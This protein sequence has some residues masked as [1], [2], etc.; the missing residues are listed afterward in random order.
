MCKIAN[1]VQ[2][3]IYI[4]QSFNGLLFYINEKKGGHEINLKEHLSS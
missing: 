4:S 3:C 1:I 2:I